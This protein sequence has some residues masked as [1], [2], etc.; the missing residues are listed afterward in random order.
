MS[1]LLSI[2]AI[3]ALLWLSRWSIRSVLR[4]EPQHRKPMVKPVYLEDMWTDLPRAPKGW[5]IE[6]DV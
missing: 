1:T 3:A 5:P 4:D 6:E 2:I